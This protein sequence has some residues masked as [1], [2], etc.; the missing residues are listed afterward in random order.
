LVKCILEFTEDD[1]PGVKKKTPLKL[2]RGAFMKIT[3]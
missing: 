1:M 2:I 3:E